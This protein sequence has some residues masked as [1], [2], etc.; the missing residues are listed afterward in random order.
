MDD[1]F[2]CLETKEHLRSYAGRSTGIPERMHSK[3][4]EPICLRHSKRMIAQV[5]RAAT[6]WL[7]LITLINN[8]KWQRSRA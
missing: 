1:S 5:R 8:N 3:T 7:E 4:T 2:L 6:R